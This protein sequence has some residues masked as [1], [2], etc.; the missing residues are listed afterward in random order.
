[1]SEVYLTL[2][3]GD[4]ISE[5]SPCDN[6]VTSGRGEGALIPVELVQVV[7]QKGIQGI[8]SSYFGNHA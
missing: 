1:M 3:D 2:R 6:F 4:G 5:E 7:G 8:V